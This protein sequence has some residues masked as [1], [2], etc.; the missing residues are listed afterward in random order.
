MLKKW[1][2]IISG[3][4]I[5]VVAALAVFWF[6]DLPDRQGRYTEVVAAYVAIMEQNPSGSVANDLVAAAIESQDHELIFAVL[7]ES[8]YPHLTVPGVED[9]FIQGAVSYI[10]RKIDTNSL[11]LIQE[12]E[13][14]GARSALAEVLP[15]AWKENAPSLLPEALAL[16]RARI[17]AAGAGNAAYAPGRFPQQVGA[18]SGLD[19]SPELW[20]ADVGTL[21]KEAGALKEKW[22]GSPEIGELINLL[23]LAEKT[24]P[25]WLSTKTQVF[26]FDHGKYPEFPGPIESAV[27]LL[28]PSL[29]ILAWADSQGGIGIFNFETW[30]HH[31]L[32]GDWAAWSPGGREMAVLAVQRQELVISF[33]REDFTKT[34]EL[35]LLPPFTELDWF[36]WPQ[37]G[38]LIVS[39]FMDREATGITESFTVDIETG[40]IEEG[41]QLIRAMKPVPGTDILESLGLFDS[42]G[43]PVGTVAERI[44]QEDSTYM[45]YRVSSGEVFSNG[46]SLMYRPDG[47]TVQVLADDGYGMWF[48]RSWVEEHEGWIYVGS[49]GPLLRYSPILNKI[50]YM[51]PPWH[52]LED[53]IEFDTLALLLAEGKAI[54]AIYNRETNQVRHWY[55]VEGSLYSVRY[56][57]YRQYYKYNDYQEIYPEVDFSAVPV[58]I[59]KYKPSGN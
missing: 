28:S 57:E 22:S 24:Q 9:A 50:E 45:V 23:T 14:L 31:Q 43:R 4:V 25:E 33:Y 34:G 11:W 41:G 13:E 53:R 52:V 2:L 30:Q 17:A 1:P 26:W 49:Q 47:G 18:P 40:V 7:E 20:Q 35:T 38:V 15:L 5:L 21:L 54:T 32:P 44:P 59:T 46:S 56:P 3:V 19:I 27:Q 8:L 36:S 58:V 12:L 48:Y 6:G 37:P 29:P 51:L 16:L 42:Q 10:E 39:R 55:S